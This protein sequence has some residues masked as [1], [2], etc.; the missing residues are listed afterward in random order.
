MLLFTDEELRGSKDK[1][2]SGRSVDA[3]VSG[4]IS[5]AIS[6]P[7]SERA[8]AHAKMF[9]EEI[10]HNHSDVE[11]IARNTGF[12]I[13]DVLHVK[14]FLFID[15][16]LLEDGEIKRFD[17]SFPIAESWRRLAFEPKLIQKH[18][19]TLLHH[20]IYERKLMAQGLSQKEAHEKASK[21]YNYPKEVE[22]FYEKLNNKKIKPWKNF[23]SGALKTNDFVR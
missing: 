19:I 23:D 5:G 14:N 7:F 11:R 4:G 10:R 6:D 2:V 8:D 18:D 13:E 17:E 1:A 3:V 22:E 21:K 15:V 20:E 12:S 16:H 9:Y